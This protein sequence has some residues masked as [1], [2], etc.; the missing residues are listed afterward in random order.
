MWLNFSV[1]LCFYFAIWDR[2]A[3]PGRSPARAGRTPARAGRTPAC[4]GHATFAAVVVAVVAVDV[5]VIGPS[6]S[7]QPFFLFWL[8]SQLLLL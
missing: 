1:F 3:R 7:L 4:A 8:L 5:C 2:L 6:L